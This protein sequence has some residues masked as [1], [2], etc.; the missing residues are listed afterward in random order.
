LH[1]G[2]P[3]LFRR[4]SVVDVVLQLLQL[5]PL[6]RLLAACYNKDKGKETK[7]RKK[8]KTS[9]FDINLYILNQ[10]IQE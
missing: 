1:T 8:R 10:L 7:E 5:S 3:W 9:N 4:Q 2:S 6:L